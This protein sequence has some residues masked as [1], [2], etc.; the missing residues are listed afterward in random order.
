MRAKCERNLSI[1][2]G[3]RERFFSLCYRNDC[4]IKNR[5][6]GSKYSVLFQEQAT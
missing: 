5:A 4:R 1:Q 3:E 6:T 2:L